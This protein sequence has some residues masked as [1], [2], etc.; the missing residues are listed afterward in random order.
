MNLILLNHNRDVFCSHPHSAHSLLCLLHAGTFC[1]RPFWQQMGAAQ[2]G[3]CKDDAINKVLRVTWPRHC[4]K[5]N[6]PVRA[7]AH[8]VAQT[9]WMLK[10]NHA[11]IKV[12]LIVMMAENCKQTRS[13]ESDHLHVRCH[14]PSTNVGNWGR[15]LRIWKGEKNYFIIIFVICI[16]T[17]CRSFQIHLN[18]TRCLLMKHYQRNKL[19]KDAFLPQNIICA[20][21]Y[22]WSSEPSILRRLRSVYE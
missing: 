17:Q 8:A 3:G 11:F 15:D 10:Q 1:G 12:E 5:P 21:I 7:C 14:S 22:P 19:V 2:V 20:V 9:Y 13:W 18:S 16:H 4:M 6:A